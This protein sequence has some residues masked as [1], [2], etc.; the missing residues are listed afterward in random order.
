MKK[1]LGLDLGVTSIGWALVNEAESK[2]EKSS[3]IKL[4]VRVNPLTVDEQNN[5]EEGKSITT[6]ATRRSKRCARRNLQRYKLRREQ[7]INIL[8]QN[9]LITNQTILYETGNASTFETLKLRAKAAAQEISLEEFARVLLMLNKKRGYKSNRKCSNSEENGQAIDSFS[10]AQQMND[11]DL[12]PGQCI[13]SLIQSGKYHFPDFYASDLKAEFDKIWNVQKQYYPALLTDSLHEELDNKESKATW[14]ILS[15]SFDLVGI[16]R[17]TKGKEQV[18]EN[19]IWRV[20]GL[21]EQLAPEQLAIVLQSINGQI[22]TASGYLGKISDRSKE[23]HIHHMTVGQFLVSKLE[24]DPNC[25]LKNKVFYRQDYMDE[26]E[27]L[28]ETQRKFHPELTE[29]LKKEIRDVIIFY[30]RRLKS[31]KDLVCFCELEQKM[32]D[33]K[34]NDKT[35]K[36]NIGPRVCPKSSPLFQEFR[37]WQNLNNLKIDEKYLSL[38]DKQTLHDELEFRCKL[39]PADIYKILGLSGKGHSMNFEEIE[40]NRTMSTLYTAYAQMIEASGNGEYD[41][42]KIRHTDAEK[43]TTEVFECLGWN[44]DILHFDTTLEGSKLLQQPTCQLWHLLYSYEGDNSRTGIEKLIN[45]IKERYNI[46]EEYAQILAKITFE[47]DYGR[48]STKALRKILPYMQ[49]GME[50]SEACSSAGYQ[51][52]KS[53]CTKEETNQKIYLDKLE[54]IRKDSLRNPVVEKILNQMVNVINAI[55]DEYG[56]PD[57]IRIELAR[58]LKKSQK[59]REKDS[60]SVRDGHKRNDEITK[61]LKEHFGFENPSRNDIIRYRLYQELAGNGYKTLYSDTYIPEEEVFSKNFDIEHI[62][63]QARFFDD[64]FSNKTLESRSINLEKRDQTAYDFV[65]LKYGQEGLAK[66]ETK[67]ETLYKNGTIGRIKKERLLTTQKDIPQ[68]FIE[69]DLRDSQYIAREAKRMLEELVPTVV[70]TSGAITARLREDW[71]LVDVMQELNWSKYEKAGQTAV[72]ERHGQKFN[73]IENWTKRNDHRHHAMDALTIAFTKRSYIQYL[74]NL[75]A[76]IPKEE[77]WDGYVD[78]SAYSVNNLPDADSSKVVRYIESNQM[79][80]DNK[81]KLR[82]IAPLENMRAEAQKELENILVSIKAKNKVGTIHT[83]YNHGKPYSQITPRGQLHKETVYGRSM[84]YV[85]EDVKIGSKTTYEVLSSV[86]KKIYRE[87]LTNRLSQFGNDPKKAFTG[88]NS[89]EKNPIYLDNAH[90]EKVPSIVKMVK[91]EPIYTIRKPIDAQL[92]LEKVV[93][94]KIREILLK[95]LEE[96]GGDKQ[97]AFS[98]MDKNPI[99][100]NEEK[101]IQIK[102]VAINSGEKPEAIHSKRDQSGNLIYNASHQTIPSDYVCTGSNHHIAI[103]EDADGNLQEHVVSFLEASVRVNELH[104][105]VVNEDYNKD[106]GWKF[107]FTMKQNEMFVFPDEE[108]DFYPED[109]DLLD[110]RNYSRIS[111]HLFRVQKLSSKFY[112]FR[113]HLETN[114]EENKN[115]KDTTWKALRNCNALKG[116]IKVRINHLGKIVHIGE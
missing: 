38:T 35:V 15:K 11:E 61:Y 24:K 54:E 72:M 27:T 110:E 43:I 58:E 111:P 14:S 44:T 114:V 32:V 88:K 76:R 6:N 8:K 78:L 71:G 89:L 50:Y 106:L 113:H 79:Y 77:E 62:L 116:I 18:K 31:Q 10:I 85:T 17:E 42:S 68:D 80:R 99:W 86:A 2:S 87:A 5:F 52:S 109:I 12:T 48:L 49:Q 104:L 63:P 57:E 105:P 95:R 98:D 81:N 53:S 59:E 16:K 93:D 97:K 103:Y 39:K 20:Q 13:L 30:Q 29:D 28:W 66:Y 101:G 47:P 46:A 92:N 64:S 91:M 73:R 65:S 3:I 83:Y 90:N 22:K 41:F 51:P 74:N 45:I 75:N 4:G 23:L 60:K 70:S 19:Y 36:I 9:N 33:K 84:R 7:L 25:S 56:K 96:Y 26:F 37:I 108:T 55:I 102:R 82:F 107:Q 1:I 112:V 40:G 34:I 67:I 21:E 94:V 69:R 115:L 100:L